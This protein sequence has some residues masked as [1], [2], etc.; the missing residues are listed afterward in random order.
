MWKGRL[1]LPEAEDRVPRDPDRRGNNILLSTQVSLSS[2]FCVQLSSTSTAP[3]PAQSLGCN[4]QNGID[5]RITSI[6]PVVQV[7]RK[8]NLFRLCF[9]S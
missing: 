7:K 4:L 8:T 9:L 3:A 5:E 6:R 1:P 2:T